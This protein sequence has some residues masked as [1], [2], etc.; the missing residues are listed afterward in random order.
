MEKMTKMSNTYEVVSTNETPIEKEI[1][2]FIQTIINEDDMLA[3]ITHAFF[4]RYD[5]ELKNV[6]LYTTAPQ[7]LEILYSS[8]FEELENLIYD[9]YKFTISIVKVDAT[10]SVVES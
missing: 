9:K 8:Q 7:Y 5:Y 4:I 6:Y 1:C 2:D 3:K 10:I